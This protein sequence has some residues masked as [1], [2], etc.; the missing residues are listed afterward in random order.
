MR[1]LRFLPLVVVIGVL[2]GLA[3]TAQ[4]A[5]I[6]PP[7]NSAVDQYFESVPSAAGNQPPTGGA[8]AGHPGTIS[9]GTRSALASSGA[10]GRAAAALAAAGAPALTAPAATAPAAAAKTAG[11]A[12]PSP[13][14]VAAPTP[15]GQ[16]PRTTAAVASSGISPVL[17][18][19]LGAALLAAIAFAVVRRRRGAPPP[20]PPT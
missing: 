13:S 20:S 18:I 19:V 8:A 17:P 3:G 1:T 12:A 9:A 5:S 4:A 10:D 16:L 11:G 14:I 2:L 15:T 6:A 7:G